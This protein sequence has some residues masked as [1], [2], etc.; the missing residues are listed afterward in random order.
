MASQEVTGSSTRSQ[1]ARYDAGMG[2][3]QASTSVPPP[4]KPE[5]AIQHVVHDYSILLWTAWAIDQTEK[6][7]D[8]IRSHIAFSYFLP[9]RAF[10]G[11]FSGQRFVP[12]KHLTSTD[13]DIQAIDFS[14]H[15]PYSD[16]AWQ[17]YQEHMN[18]HLF[19]LN[20]F[21]TDSRAHP[22]D[23]YPVVMT[24]FAEFQS[25]WR[26]FI[27]GLR[28]NYPEKFRRHIDSKGKELPEVAFYPS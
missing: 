27:D 24:L 5:L 13:V 17:K 4:P 26:N 6:F 15:S 16:V 10:A 2:R 3:T 22:F 9:H 7:S 18:T 19:H 8:I 28:G 14:N 12:N 25:N 21:R 1:G 20:Y 11:F 23:P